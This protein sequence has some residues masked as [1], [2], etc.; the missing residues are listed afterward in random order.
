M[1]KSNF[2]LIIVILLS[3][4]LLSSCSDDFLVGIGVVAVTAIVLAILK[5]GEMAIRL[6]IIKIRGDK[7]DIDNCDDDTKEE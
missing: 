2:T 7:K 1:K 4:T 3:S 6:L 5:F